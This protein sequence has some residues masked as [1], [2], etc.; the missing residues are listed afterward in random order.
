M[1]LCTCAC[2]V[3]RDV[4]VGEP[5]AG[6]GGDAGVE[7]FVFFCFVVERGGECG[8]VSRDVGGGKSVTVS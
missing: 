7:S 8:L 3:F 2:V 4:N 5:V 1:C 6:D